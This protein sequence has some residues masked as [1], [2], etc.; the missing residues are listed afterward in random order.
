VKCR[1]LARC[2]PTIAPP[3]VFAGDP[4]PAPRPA[5]DLYVP[6]QLNYDGGYGPGAGSPSPPP[7]PAVRPGTRPRH[8]GPHP[9]R[10]RPDPQPDPTPAPQPVAGELELRQGLNG[11][12]GVTDVGVSN[13]GTQ[14]NYGKGVVVPTGKTGA[15]R[16]DGS[17]GYEMRS[18]VRF[19]G[20]ETLAGRRVARVPSWR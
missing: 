10:R 4:P 14:Y 17:S 20:L 15:F 16:I 6:E 11:Y 18:F 3:P 7:A 13:Q 9:H 12:Q 1:W 5:P 8:R 19:A 2:P